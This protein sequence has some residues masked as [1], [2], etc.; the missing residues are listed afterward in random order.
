MAS[1]NFLFPLTL[2][3]LE[4]QTFWWSVMRKFALGHIFGELEPF[5]HFFHNGQH[6][7]SFSLDIQKT[8]NRIFGASVVG[9]FTLGHFIFFIMA[10]PKPFAKAIFQT[11]FPN[12]FP[13]QIPKSFLKPISQTHFPNHFPNHF[14]Y[15][16]PKPIYRNIS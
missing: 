11:Y 8:R 16:F 5:F 15:L 10:D 9:S 7:F 3:K 4:T 6:K 12:P 14:P 1:A 2:G 13:T